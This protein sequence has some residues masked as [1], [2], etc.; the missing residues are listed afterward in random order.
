MDWN[1]VGPA[2]VT[3]ALAIAGFLFV[4]RYGGGAA[5]AELERANRVLEKAVKQLQEDNARLTGEV[6]TLRASRDVG[7]AIMPV[8][9]AL[10]RHED[11]AA[12]RAER[13][14]DLLGLMAA[15][16]GP[17]PDTA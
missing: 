3:I 15:R 11:R 13:T 12:E 14:L 2:V 6:A 1:S 16:L 7:L 10:T 9:E 17:E 8:L 4:R 5:M